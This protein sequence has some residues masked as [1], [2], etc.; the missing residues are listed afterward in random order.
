[1]Q[2]CEVSAGA[3]MGTARACSDLLPSGC[4]AES[5]LFA[6]GTGQMCTWRHCWGRLQYQFVEPCMAAWQS[7][8]EKSAVKR[9]P[10]R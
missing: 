6:M 8:C 1:M 9:S 3:R 5:Q 2:A 4:L 10:A 7:R